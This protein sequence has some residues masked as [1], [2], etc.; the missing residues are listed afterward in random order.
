MLVDHND[1]EYTFLA[2][3]FP[4]LRHASTRAS[5]KVLCTTG[6][7]PQLT[8]IKAS[9]QTAVHE[10]SVPHRLRLKARSDTSS[11]HAGFAVCHGVP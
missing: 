10:D 5:R 2:H 3:M 11:S 4:S 7:T 1:N 6:M 9:G 8:Y